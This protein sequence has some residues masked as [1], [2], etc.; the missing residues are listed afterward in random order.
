VTVVELAD[1]VA[2]RVR[3]APGTLADEAFGEELVLTSAEWHALVQV[4]AHARLARARDGWGTPADT[5]M[6]RDLEADRG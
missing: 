5:R 6:A 1:G 4:A 3:H 2:V